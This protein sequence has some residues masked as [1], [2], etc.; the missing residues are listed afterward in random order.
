MNSSSRFLVFLLVLW[1][2]LV[3]CRGTQAQVPPTDGEE[4]AMFEDSYI[5]VDWKVDARAPQYALPVD[6]AR[7]TNR[8]QVERWGLRKEIELLLRRNG[9]AVWQEHA[10]KE[11]RM[12]RF[13]RNLQDEDTPVFITSDSLLHLYHI[14]FQSALE[15]IEEQHL[16]IDLRMLSE[17]ML[18]AVSTEAAGVDGK[19]EEALNL[20]KDY[21]AVPAC[22]AVRAC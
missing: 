22:P 8:D 12:W 11:D 18:A 21:F 7:L 16:F 5:E 10:E 13:Y 17:G 9:F 6:L 2:A 1:F 14:C 15:S 4:T 20:A 19:A 3:P